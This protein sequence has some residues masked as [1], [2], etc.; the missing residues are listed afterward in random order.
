MS[1]L[2]PLFSQC[3]FF[4]LRAT[5]ATLPVKLSH[6]P[7]KLQ[8]TIQSWVHESSYLSDTT[9]TY[10]Q[11]NPLPPFAPFPSWFHIFQ[12]PIQRHPPPTE[13]VASALPYLLPTL[14]AEV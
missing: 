9:V 4:K 11:Y 3:K 8:H 7:K 13:R 12:I 2:I 5:K 6:K 14:H 1:A 10:I